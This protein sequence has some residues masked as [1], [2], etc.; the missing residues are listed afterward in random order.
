MKYELNQG[1]R[2]YYTGDMANIEDFG[3][4]VKINPP[5]R[6]ATHGT[7]D[8]KLDD[9]REINGIYPSAFDPGPGRRFM[10]EAENKANRAASIKQMIESLNH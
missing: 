6:F 1:T 3:S 9:G 7:I 8:M 10:T 5:S 4:I 2:I